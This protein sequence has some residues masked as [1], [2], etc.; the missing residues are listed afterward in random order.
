[1]TITA[2]QLSFTGGEWSPSLYVRTDLQK[3]ATAARKM[4]NFIVHPH[5]G[6][7]N[8]GGTEFISEVKDS[9]KYTRLVPF[10]FSVTQSYVLEFG[11]NY[12][13]VLKDGGVVVLTAVNITGA[14][15]AN[16]VRISCNIATLTANDQVVISGIGGMT[17]LNGRT[18][19]LT[20][21]SSGGADLQDPLGTNIDGTNYGT[22]T[23]GGQLEEIY[24]ITT[25]YA[26]A[27]LREL[28]FTQ[29]ADS[30]YIFHKSYAPAV[31]TRTGHTSWTLSTITFGASLTAPTG[32]S[33]LTAGTG[34]NIKVKVTA[35]D[36][37]GIETLPSPSLT[38]A[39]KSS[40]FNWGA[41]TGAA[42]YN[43]YMEAPYGSG[44]YYWLAQTIDSEYTTASTAYEPDYTIAPPVSY[45]PFSASNKYPAM[46]SFFEQRMVYA[47]SNNYPQTIWGSRVLDFNNLN[48][49]TP[50]T[51]VSMYEFTIYSTQVNEI[52]WL[53]PLDDLVIGTADGEWRM[54]AGSS[55]DTVT[56]SSVLL[57][58][59]SQ[60]GC[61]SLQ[62][63]VIG[64]AILFLQ[65]S[66]NTIRDLSYN[67]ESDGYVGN[68]V[69]I[70]ATHL[71]K[72]YQ[73]LEWA[74][75]ASPDSIVWCV[76]NDGTLLGFT[77]YKEHEIMAWHHHETDGVFESIACIRDGADYEVYAVVKRTIG[78]VDRRYVEFFAER[79]PFDTDYEYDV[80]KAF[81]VDC[82]L[83]YSGS[84]ITTVGGLWHLEGETVAALCDGNVVS[85]LTVT[86][87]TVTLPTSASVIAIGLPYE[88]ELET[89]DFIG[90]TQ[91]GTIQ[92]KLRNVKTAIVSLEN[93]RSLFYGPND[94][95]LSEVPFRTNEDY[96]EPIALFT[97][98][99]ELVL[100]AGE[101][102]S[103]KMYF[104]VTDPVPCTIL[105]I[106][107]RVE[108]GND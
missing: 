44:F 57:R 49:T 74:Y 1:M 73:I 72:G 105:G 10:Q 79:L 43:V 25:T 78:G 18:F 50:I 11:H 9:S 101:E 70:F 14:T 75:Q 33:Y 62:P 68:D 26:E 87:G 38:I 97:G 88:S 67:F 100:D 37:S 80:T 36:A 59:Q 90:A 4:K 45:T 53:V 29:S 93:T 47:R 82:G 108:Y 23:S 85:N 12:I 86:N 42:Y 30:L 81:F 60:W 58:R 77:Y 99:K 103:S 96:G 39:Q 94:Q 95:R 52:R 6:A 21:V 106:Q 104:K 40:R 19:K 16:P 24:Q 51:A 3:Y 61:A 20:N 15:N 7:S 64:K 35:V 66:G 54:S 31:L 34:D 55:G 91:E 56:A 2:R 98:D 8:R 102:R 5:G 41:V 17:E 92:D 65:A 28:K 27:D 71:F 48:K 22:Y 13:R 107:P 69:T 63:I 84:P 76:R 83:T 46:G 89:L 32:L